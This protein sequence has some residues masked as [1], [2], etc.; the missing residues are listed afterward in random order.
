MA[1]HHKR[2][3]FAGLCLLMLFLNM[4]D[5]ASGRIGFTA[6][7]SRGIGASVLA[8]PLFSVVGFILIWFVSKMYLMFRNMLHPGNMIKRLDLPLIDKLNYSLAVGILVKVFL[9]ARI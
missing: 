4:P 1:I 6:S 9:G 5:F 7:L 8:I 3:I 2:V